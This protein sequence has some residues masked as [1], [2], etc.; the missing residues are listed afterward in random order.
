MSGESYGTQRPPHRTFLETHRV[1]RRLWQPGVVWRESLVFFTYHPRQ[2][3]GATD[4]R[5]QVFVGRSRIPR[6]VRERFVRSRGISLWLAL[7]FRMVLHGATLLALE[8]QGTLCAYAWIRRCDPFV[9]RY[10]WLTPRGVL[11]GYFWTEPAMQRRGLFGAL[12]TACVAICPDRRH[13]P[14]IVYADTWNNA[15]ILG[16]EKA[17]FVRLGT[18]NVTSR[19]MGLINKHEVIREYATLDDVWSAD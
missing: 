2:G 18:Y 4:E 19:L 3:G 1:L 8:E 17:G 6:E 16:L 7:R 11:L 10:R 12:L 15:S 14:I 9:R 13:M 5:I